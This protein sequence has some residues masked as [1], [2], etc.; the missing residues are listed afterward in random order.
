VKNKR[1]ET[2]KSKCIQTVGLGGVL[3]SKNALQIKTIRF[4][5]KIAFFSQKVSV[6]TLFCPSF[7][8]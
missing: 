7:F 2:H 3:S 6:R 4:N 8:P 1:V 5:A